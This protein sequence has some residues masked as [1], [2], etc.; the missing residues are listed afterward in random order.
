MTREE[1]LKAFVQLGELMRALGSGEAYSGYSIGITEKEYESLNQ[2]IIRKKVHNGWFTE[3]NVRKSV[4]ALGKE[5]TSE[6]LNDWLEPYDYTDY[7]K[8]VSVIMAGN[9]PLV[10]FHDFMCVLFSGNKIIAKLSSEDKHLLPALTEVLLKFEPRLAERISFSHGPM[11]GFDAVIATGSNNSFTYFE[12]YFGKYP[13]IFRKNRTSVAVLNGTETE[14]EL[15]ALGKDLF[16]YFGLGCRN[17][18]QL[19]IPETFDLDNFFKAILPYNEVI[20][21]KKYGNN[22][23][24]NKAVFL[25]NKENL[26]DNNFVLLHE[27]D[28]LFSPLSVINYKRYQNVEELQEFI[29]SRQEDIQLVVGKNYIPFGEA[30]CPRLNDYADGVDTM[31]WLNELQ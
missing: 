8:T 16:D 30:Q 18:S 9:I 6:K 26:L 24:Y 17:V 1:I 23:D 29:I 15:K 3:E 2:L 10:G 5:L 13:H 28:A 7:P 12:S 27:N 4:L 11:K 14:E 19:F 31:K 20:Y 21:N 22:Y 25:L